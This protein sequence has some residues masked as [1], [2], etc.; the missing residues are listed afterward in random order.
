VHLA[1][2]RVQ[3]AALI[4]TLLKAQEF[5]AADALWEWAEEYLDVNRAELEEEL[6]I[7]A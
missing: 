6:E 1:E 5:D 7:D 4:V 3:F 2:A